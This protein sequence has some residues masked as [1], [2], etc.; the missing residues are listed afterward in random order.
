[1]YFADYLV[2]TSDAVDIFPAKCNVMRIPRGRAD[3][4]ELAPV[5]K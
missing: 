1:M 4:P 5:E 2:C 3:S